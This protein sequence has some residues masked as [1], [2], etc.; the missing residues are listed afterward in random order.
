[1]EVTISYR[2]VSYRIVSYR[3]VSYRI[4]SY[5]IVSY[6]IDNRIILLVT[7]FKRERDGALAHN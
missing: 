3:I 1:M 7:L 4:V 6:R 5:R 2:I